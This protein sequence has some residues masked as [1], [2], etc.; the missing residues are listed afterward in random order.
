MLL[1]ATPF[2]LVNSF[3]D[4]YLGLHCIWAAWLISVIFWVSSSL[5]R[6]LRSYGF[7]VILKKRKSSPS[8]P[9]IAECKRACGIVDAMRFCKYVIVHA[10]Q[11]KIMWEPDFIILKSQNINTKKNTVAF[12]FEFCLKKLYYMSFKKPGK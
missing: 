1:G 12:S 5:G 4:H 11:I 7:G 9:A 2:H 8:V 10:F 3:R 6:G